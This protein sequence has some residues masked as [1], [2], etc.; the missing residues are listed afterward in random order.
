MHKK[1]RPHT[2]LHRFSDPASL[3]NPHKYRPHSLLHQLPHSLHCYLKL[4]MHPHIALR[5]VSTATSSHRLFPHLASPLPLLLPSPCRACAGPR[6]RARIR[7]ARP[8]VVPKASNVRPIQPGRPARPA[9][10]LLGHQPSVSHIPGAA[11]V[12]KGEAAA[13]DDEDARSGGRSVLASDVLLVPAGVHR[14][15]GAVCGAG[16]HPQPRALHPQQL[17]P[18]GG[19]WREGG[20]WR[21]EGLIECGWQSA[22]PLSVVGSLPRLC[23]AVECGRQSATLFSQIDTALPSL[24]P[25]RPVYA[26]AGGNAIPVGHISGE[27]QRQLATAAVSHSSR[28]THQQ[29]VT[30]AATYTRVWSQQR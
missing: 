28:W 1:K 30:A 19:H 6:T 9:F 16:Q 2:W 27:P 4:C 24:S 3:H 23:H 29:L 5:P 7:A 17:R 20:A 18:T 11:G 15:H 12:R 21:L 25:T 22:T 10:L 13:H 26:Q 8:H 14:L